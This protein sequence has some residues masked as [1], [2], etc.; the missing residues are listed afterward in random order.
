MRRF[1]MNAISRNTERWV[2]R[3]CNKRRIDYAVNGLEDQNETGD[4]SQYQLPGSVNKTAVIKAFN[5]F[6]YN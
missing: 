5:S 2:S 3:I 6:L 4:L 1:F